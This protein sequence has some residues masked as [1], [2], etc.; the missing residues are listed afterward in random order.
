MRTVDTLIVP[1]TFVIALVVV[2]SVT[3]SWVPHPV[4]PL[5]IQV[6]M[7]PPGIVPHRV[8][9]L[10]LTPRNALTGHVPTQV[11]SSQRRCVD[12]TITDTTLTYFDPARACRLK[13]GS[14]ALPSRFPRFDDYVLFV[15]VQPVGGPPKA[16]RL[17]LPLDR[18]MLQAHGR[19]RTCPP[20]PA[21][22]R[23]LE[24]VRSHTVRGLTVVLGAPAHAAMTG[25][26]VAV[27]FVVLRRGRAVRD[28][29]PM[30]DAPG[31][32]V[33]ISMDTQSFTRLQPDPGQVAHG[34]VMG[35][36][37]SFTGWFVHAGIYRVFG[38]FRYRGRPLRT[39]FVIDVNPHH[40]RMG[41]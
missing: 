23:G 32:S 35:G 9:A 5:P 1:A 40:A 17:V 34:R 38:T 6:T 19:Q 18:C 26:P 28:L 24:L 27:S 22:L 41:G 3:V 12:V 31:Q 14:Y 29:E 39:S 8:Y 21:R 11:V 33:A 4:P 37:V 30:G 25:E 36:A 13:N 10:R 16:Y 15:A 7:A 2:L 20:H